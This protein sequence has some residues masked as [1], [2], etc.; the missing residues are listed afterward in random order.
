M[1]QSTNFA[2]ERPSGMHLGGVTR[3]GQRFS[4]DRQTASEMCGTVA[5]IVILREDDRLSETKH[6]TVSVNGELIT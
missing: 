3:E 1:S 6:T 4:T 5:K 2:T